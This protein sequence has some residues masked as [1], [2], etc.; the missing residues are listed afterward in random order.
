MIGK[1]SLFAAICMPSVG[2]CQNLNMPGNAVATHQEA[3]APN[4]LQ[5]A[6][7]PWSNGTLPQITAEGTLA[8]SSWKIGAAGLTTLQ[9]LLPLRDQLVADGYEEL[10]TCVD[11]TCGGYDF[12]FALDVL[13]PPDM[14]VNLGD[15]RYW[16]GR[17]NGENGPE[18]VTILISQIART[19]YVQIDQVA[20]N[21]DVGRVSSQGAAVVAATKPT[22]TETAPP[23]MATA[24]NSVGRAVLDDLTFANGSADLADDTYTSLKTLAAY[25]QAN[26][27]LQ[28]ALVGHTDAS[29]SLDGNIALSKRRARAVR[30]RLINRY[31]IPASQLDAQGM[32]YLSPVESNLTVSG[33]DAN[34]RVEAIITS[35]DID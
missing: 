30:Q 26:P 20:N 34:R 35:T 6:T 11:D 14:Q 12:R 32:G 33:R 31:D 21:G 10:F 13:P 1:A 28:I 25:L 9:V 27:S 23:D 16:S 18:Y 24:L 5:V 4:T 2:F 8:Q 22:P 15:F 17:K 29:G 19:G 7:A 3:G